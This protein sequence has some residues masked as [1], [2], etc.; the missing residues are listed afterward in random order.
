MNI[1]AGE[2]HLWFVYDDDIQD[3]TLISKCHNILSIQERLQLKRFY[4]DKHRHQYLISRVLTR[5]ALSMYMKNVSPEEWQFTKNCYGKP[6]IHNPEIE[7]PLQFNLSHTENLI[8]LGVTL[9]DELGVDVENTIRSRD[10]IDIAKSHFSFDEVQ[11]ITLAS[12]E[13]KNSLF[14][15]FWTLKEAYIKACGMGLSIPLD[16][17]GFHFP[18][19][20]EIS[21]TFDSRRND[22][23]EYWRFWQIQ[24]GNNYKVA[25][26]IKSDE[27]NT[28]YSISTKKLSPLLDIIEVD[29]PIIAATM[30]QS[31]V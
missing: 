20:G 31:R 23:P 26:A 15:D 17:F 18:Q 11:Q 8:V 5:I 13:I 2:I 12:S 16:Q 29:Y 6:R 10:L 27:T 30:G 28:N 21:I 22:R 1:S 7:I 9:H 3:P 25:V 24:P 14:F 4:F 19:P